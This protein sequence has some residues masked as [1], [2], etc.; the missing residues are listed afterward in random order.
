M[1]YFDLQYH[2]TVHILLTKGHLN[3]QTFV[4]TLSALLLFTEFKI[5]IFQ[6]IARFSL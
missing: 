3:T 1:E 6:Y 2:I 4:Q 5:V